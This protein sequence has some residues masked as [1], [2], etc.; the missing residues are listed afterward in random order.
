MGRQSAV[1]NQI[2]STELSF[3]TRRG[4]QRKQQH[5]HCST[6]NAFTRNTHPR[7]NNNQIPDKVRIFEDLTQYCGFSFNRLNNV[8]GLISTVNEECL[9]DWSLYT[10]RLERTH[11][12]G[13]STFRE[14]QLVVIGYFFELCYDICLSAR[15][16]VSRN[17]GFNSILGVFDNSKTA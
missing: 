12:R 7:D 6:A 1:T 15:Y 16:N 17:L 13:C 3:G 8:S 10:N 14:K 9:L 11:I 4:M 2:Q 5:H